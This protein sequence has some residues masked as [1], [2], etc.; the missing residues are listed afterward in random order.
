MIGASSGRRL[1]ALLVATGV[2]AL[3]ACSGSGDPE[4]TTGAQSSPEASTPVAAARAAGRGFGGGF[5]QLDETQVEA[6]AACLE[7]REFEIPDGASTLQAL[8]GGGPSS[9]E[10]QN[11]LQDC[12]AELG[13]DLPGGFGGGGG[14]FGGGAPDRE[15]L[16]ECLSA[17]GLD[18]EELAA[19]GGGDGGQTGLFADLDRD[20]PEV[21]AALEVCAPG[22]GTRPNGQ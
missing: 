7:G 14:G 2:L 15:A 4:S 9:A 1:L 11:A 12:A 19:A 21:Q 22:F 5:T 13:V 16:L 6:L 8:F 3:A 18:V 10:F 17:E 20:D